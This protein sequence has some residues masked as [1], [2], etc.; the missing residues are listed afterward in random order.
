MFGP[1]GLAGVGL[2]AAGV[3]PKGLGGVAGEIVAPKKKEVPPLNP[4]AP[5][6]LRQRATQGR[7][8]SS[9]PV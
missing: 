5:G 6:A 7:G 9:L 3:G 8:A 1:F 4:D 2:R